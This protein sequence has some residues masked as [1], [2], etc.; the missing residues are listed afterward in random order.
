[1]EGEWKGTEDRKVFV[2]SKNVFRED[3][4]VD[5]GFQKLDLSIFY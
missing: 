5:S 1:M 3:Y 2:R 4:V